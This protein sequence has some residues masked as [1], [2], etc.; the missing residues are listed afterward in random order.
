MTPR[1]T[2][3]AGAF[4]LESERRSIS[5]AMDANQRISSPGFAQAHPADT[6]QLHPHPLDSEGAGAVIRPET[7]PAL[8]L[9]LEFR[10]F[11]A[12]PEK[13][14][15]KAGP[16]FFIAC[17]GTDFGA[18]NIQG[19]FSTL[20]AVRA[21]RRPACDGAVR[22]ASHPQRLRQTSTTTLPLL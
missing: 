11:R 3:Q 8:I 1:S 22:Q 2:P 13:K 16:R 4:V 15:A 12:R 9:R 21:R 14:A 10:V 19:N 7:F 20:I 17:C 6:G 18:C 5:A